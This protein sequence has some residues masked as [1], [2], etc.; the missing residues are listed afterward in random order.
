[1]FRFRLRT[2]E[3][4]FT[5]TVLVDWLVEEGLAADRFEAVDLGNS[6]LQGRVIEHCV[7]EHFFYDLPYFY[8]FTRRSFEMSV[9]SISFGSIT[10]MV[11]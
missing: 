4:V 5:G 10:N 6:L 9:D 2:F 3:G 11:G 7:R 8:Q 1:L